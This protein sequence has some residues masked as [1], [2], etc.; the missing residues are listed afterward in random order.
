MPRILFLTERYP[1]D[2][3]GVAASAGRISRGLA[4]EGSQVG[5]VAWSRSIEA[6]RVLHVEGNPDVYRMGRFRQWDTTMP[7]TLNLVDW[8][9]GTRAYD[10]VWGHYLSPAGFLA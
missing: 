4:A 8:L 7:H 3:G 5:G 6:G 1:P 9:N 2:A 10:A